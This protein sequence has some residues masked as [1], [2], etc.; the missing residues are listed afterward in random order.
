[1]KWFKLWIIAF[2][3]CGFGFTLN[4]DV[5][6]LTTIRS[7]FYDAILDSRKAIPLGES[8]TKIQSKSSLIKVYEGATYAIMAKEKWNPFSALK[9]LG[10]SID[11]MD[12]AVKDAPTNLEIR[13]I[14]FAVQKNIPSFLGY[15]KNTI[16]D[17]NYIIKHISHFESNMLSQE[18]KDYILSFMIKQGGY[19]SEEIKAINKQFQ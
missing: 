10:M 19:N 1:M 2:T 9:L 17:K 7:G 4:A 15:S 13:F 3:Y 16:E 6:Q 8:I 12:E 11:I 14:R 18:M 5:V